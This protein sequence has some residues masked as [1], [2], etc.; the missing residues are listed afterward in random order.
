MK[1]SDIK[2]GDSLK[3]IYDG[4]IQHGELDTIT[5]YGDYCIFQKVDDE[6]RKWFK[7]NADEI[8]AVIKYIEEPINR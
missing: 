8:L 2:I 7:V 4:V 5:A 3:F 1:I 6:H